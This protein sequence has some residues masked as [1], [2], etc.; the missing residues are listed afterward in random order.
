V[1]TA[2]KTP[3]WADAY[4]AWGNRPAAGRDFPLQQTPAPAK[5]IGG[6]FPLGSP[7]AF[8]P[9]KPPPIPAGYYDPALDAQRDAASRGLVNLEQD[10][11]LQGRWAQEDLGTARTDLT[12]QAGDATWDLQTG[13]NRSN[14][15]LATQRG[16]EGVDYG[17]NVEMLTRQTAQLGRQQA[18]QARKYGV[19][20]GGIALLSA[21]KRD[22]NM[23]L[24]QRDL[25]TAHQRAVSGFD[26]AG[27]RAAADYQG[28]NYR[29]GRDLG[30]AETALA[31]T[32]NRGVATRGDQLSRAR[33]E[34]VFYGA[35]VGQQK[36]Y[37]AQQAG[38]DA[39]A[40]PGNERLLPDGR[41]V[42]DKREGKFIVTRDQTGRVVSRKKAK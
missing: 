13:F 22:E 18:E 35:D 6:Q 9:Y 40:G 5:G 10:I 28:A 7:Y 14:E 21:A 36:Q 33:A 2:K 42:R 39:P 32:Y 41:T 4:T 23:G 37:Q 24:A 34:D 16:Y 19:T 27:Q 12:T 38:Y 30:T 11:G 17:R 29:I 25:D 8:T 15:D 1:A 31:T 3:S 26:T 20:S